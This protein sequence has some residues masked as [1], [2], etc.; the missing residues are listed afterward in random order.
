MSVPPWGS[1]WPQFVSAHRVLVFLLFVG[2]LSSGLWQARRVSLSAKITDYY[3]ST[4]PHVHLYQQFSE[5]LRMA[6]TVVVTVTVK[7][8]TIYTND[9][10][11]KVHRL[12]VDLIETRGANA[13]E[14][15]SLTHP[16]LKDIRVSSEDIEIMPV[17]RQPGETLPPETL[18][19]IKN[20]VYTNL[21]IRGVY[22]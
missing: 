13:N 21:G 16:R 14:I 15:L 3:P 22:V 1:R 2:V 11:G 17:V 12:T 6:N 4:H 8:G 5:M 20:A 7:D 9:A 18:A 19:R 10:L